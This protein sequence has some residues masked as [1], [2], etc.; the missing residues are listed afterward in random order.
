MKTRITVNAEHRKCS[1]KA[2][3]NHRFY[4]SP[5][6]RQ[7][8]GFGS[9][10]LPWGHT[11]SSTARRLVEKEGLRP[12]QSHSSPRVS[13]CSDVWGP[14]GRAHFFL[15]KTSRTPHCV[16]PSVH[17]GLFLGQLLCQGLMAWE[18]VKG[19]PVPMAVPAPSLPTPT[20]PVPA[21]N[22]SHSTARFSLC[23]GAAGTL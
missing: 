13:P 16:L 21:S 23:S 15:C 8:W 22:R 5:G 11:W 7:A 2:S 12:A 9:G 4:R 10:K 17:L 1:L 6:V 19:P 20:A 18:L 3:D 14:L